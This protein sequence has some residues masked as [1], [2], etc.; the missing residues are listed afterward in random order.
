MHDA[1]KLDEYLKA[2]KISGAEFAELIGVDAATVF[3]I[4]TGRVFPHRR[5]MQSIITATDGQ[6]SANDLIQ[7]EPRSGD[8][9]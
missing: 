9:D 1:M 7:A 4:R 2:N 5:T 8:E 6:V 3:R